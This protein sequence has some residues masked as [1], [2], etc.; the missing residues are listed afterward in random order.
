[1]I[2][3]KVD[4]FTGNLILNNVDSADTGKY[5]LE[6]FYVYVNE[7]LTTNLTVNVIVS[8]KEIF[9]CTK[10]HRLM[11]LPDRLTYRHTDMIIGYKQN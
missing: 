8:G 7:F 6:I 1:M 10:C 4:F 5:T 11:K 3:F 2:P 9:G